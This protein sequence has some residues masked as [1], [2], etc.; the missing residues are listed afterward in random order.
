VKRGDLVKQAPNVLI[1]L[2]VSDKKMLVLEVMLDSAHFTGTTV[3]TLLEGKE[4]VWHYAELEVV[5][6][7]R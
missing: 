5:S 7:A 4:R 1:N 2:T 3:R 6:E